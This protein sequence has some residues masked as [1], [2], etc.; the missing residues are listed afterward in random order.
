MDG[1]LCKRHLNP[2]HRHRQAHS[3]RCRHCRSHRRARSPPRRSRGRRSGS[4]F[5]QRAAPPRAEAPVARLRRLVAA[6]LADRPAGGRRRPRASSWSPS[7][8]WNTRA[9]RGGL[10]ARAAQR[11]LDALAA[12]HAQPRQRAVGC[13]VGGRVGA[14]RCGG[15]QT[16]R[17]VHRAVGPVEV[18]TS[19]H[20]FFGTDSIAVRCIWR[21]GANVVKPNRIGKFTVTA[22]TP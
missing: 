22:P 16:H 8:G 19:E 21:F 7:D 3:R 18:A 2:T 13:G 14:G 17:R 6:L 12:T 11:R 1:S 10:A 9:R 5:Y 4:R 15:Q 20:A